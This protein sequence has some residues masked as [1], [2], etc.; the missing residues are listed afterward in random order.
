VQ[1][2]LGLHRTAGDRLA[3]SETLG[4]QGD[5]LAAVDDPAGARRAWQAAVE[6]LDE[7]DH[8]GAE[9]VRARL[10]GVTEPARPS[11]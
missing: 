11:G 9:E 8:P 2:A 7:L 3:E 4:H 1:L 10:A 6:I 5:S